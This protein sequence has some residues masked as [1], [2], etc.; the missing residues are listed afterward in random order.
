MLTLEFNHYLDGNGQ[1][2]YRLFDDIKRVLLDTDPIIILKNFP[3]QTNKALV[4]LSLGLGVPNRN[5][6]S[7]QVDMEDSFIYNVEARQEGVKD[8]E[9]NWIYSTTH[10]E[11]NCHTDGSNNENP[12]DWVLLLCVRPD[13]GGGESILFDIQDIISELSLQTIQLL[14]QPVY[15]FYFGLAPILTPDG[16][17]YEIRY[18]RRDIDVYEK[19]RQ[20]A[21]P[22][23]CKKALDHLDQVIKF[24][25]TKLRFLL[26]Q[27]DCLI[28]NNK[29]V[30][31]GR[32][33]FNH[34]SNRLLKRVRLY[35]AEVDSSAL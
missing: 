24:S 13:L 20:L 18:N 27:G 28:I 31:H 15:P 2:S 21:I 9:G 12:Y 17:S 10:H 14:S 1:I 8:D 5:T 22:A 11:F 16:S 6:S 3:T 34:N 32:T 33:A 23:D 4:E 26:N 7:I 35:L 25:N 19:S 30:L 29:K